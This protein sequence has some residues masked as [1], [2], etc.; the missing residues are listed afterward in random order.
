MRK[1]WLL[2]LKLPNGMPVYLTELLGTGN[3]ALVA[4]PYLAI[5]F[6]ECE[7]AVNHMKKCREAAPP[8]VRDLVMALKPQEHEFQ[9]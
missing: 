2:E 3:A 4:D 1:V 9:L 5:Q 7:Y 6:T 8:E